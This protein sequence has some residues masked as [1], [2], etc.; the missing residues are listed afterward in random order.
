M[1]RKCQTQDV[2]SVTVSQEAVDDFNEH[3]QEFMKRTAW[4]TH[5]RSW[6]KNGTVDGP[7]VALHPG[8]RIHWFHMLNEPR[9]EDF[10]WQRQR[11]NRFSY[12]GNGFSTKESEGKDTAYYFNNPESGFEFVNKL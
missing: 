8:S 4:S 1:I 2:K 5:C 12:L 11:A 9:Y 6:F 3:I 7:I 10:I